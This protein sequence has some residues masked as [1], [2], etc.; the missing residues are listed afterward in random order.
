MQYGNRVSRIAS[1][2]SKIL[3]LDSRFPYREI[4]DPIYQN[5]ICLSM[6]GLKTQIN[7]N[8]SCIY[9]IVNSK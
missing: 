7:Q 1:L 6:L 2:F 4:K 5:T 8:N 3:F 9:K